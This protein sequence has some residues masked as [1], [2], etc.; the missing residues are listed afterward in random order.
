MRAA[1]LV[2][3]VGNI[4]LRDE[5]VGVRVVEA[6]QAVEIPKG[7]ELYD[8][9]TAGF[10]LLDVLADRRKVIIVDAVD[11]NA[12]PGTVFRLT[13]EDLMPRDGQCASLH[14]MGVLE[15][16]ELV[17]RLGIAPEEVVII[18]IKPKELSWGL[19][20]SPEIARVV[21]E[22]IELLLAEL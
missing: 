1:T 3:G 22:V 7:V 5:G 6:M 8:G 10:D 12:E 4:L 11:G 16:L 2:L 20:L 18:G 13:P 21:P 15:T 14:D 17:K 19:E 9:A